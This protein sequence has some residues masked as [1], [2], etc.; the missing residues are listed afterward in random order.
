MVKILFMAKETYSSKCSLEYLCEKKDEIEIV[1]AVIRHNDL[2]L[3]KICMDNEI[4]ILT[5]EEIKVLYNQGELNVDYIFSYYWKKIGKDLLEIPKAGCLNFHPGPLPEARGSGYHVAIL[6][7]WN[8]WGVTVHYM[9]E[10]FDTGAI[11]ECRRFAIDDKIVN[12][13]LVTMAHEQLFVLFKDTIQKIIGGEKLEKSIQTEGRYFSLSELERDKFIRKDETMEDIDRKIRAFWNPPYSG[14]Q[15]EI[16][17]TRYTII[18]EE[19]L[20]WISERIGVD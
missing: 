8:Y 17:G 1:G 18:N 13:D 6:E 3:Q 19:I 14:A 4:R 12:K 7:K 15:I 5:E 10:Q 16:N 20:A 2:V 11:I 9:D